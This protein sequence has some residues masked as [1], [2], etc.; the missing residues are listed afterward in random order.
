M[1]VVVFLSLSV[2]V[3][4]FDGIVLL[5]RLACSLALIREFVVVLLCRKRYDSLPVSTM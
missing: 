3:T 4:S 5:V 1:P 2:Q